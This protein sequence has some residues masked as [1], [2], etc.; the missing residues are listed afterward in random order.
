MRRNALGGSRGQH[1]GGALLQKQTVHMS[2]YDALWKYIGECGEP[3][4]TLTFEKIA[5]IS[6]APLDHSFLKYKKELSKYGAKVG[7]ISVKA[8]TVVFIKEKE[9]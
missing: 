3:R 9:A 6:G 2:K 7:K 5:E 8:Q 1:S 4:I